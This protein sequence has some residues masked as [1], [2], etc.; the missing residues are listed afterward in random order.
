MQK[1]SPC[2]WFNFNAET[3][4]SHYLGIF[5]DSRVLEVAHYG[6]AMPEFKGRVMMIVFEL[7]G[8]RMLALNGGPQFSFNEAISLA[9]DCDSQAE[10][11]DLWERLAADGGTPGRCGWV[12]D[13]FGVSWQIVPRRVVALLGDHDVEKAS[14]AMK[15]MMQMHKI[16]IAAMES[17]AQG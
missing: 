4:V 17:A 3:A 6:D 9:V 16:D 15:S 14:R 7:E 13:K 10:V 2:L 11:D 1:I 12:K 5:K 8:M